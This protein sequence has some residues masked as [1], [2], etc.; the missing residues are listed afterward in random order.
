MR[1][2]LLSIIPIL[3][4]LT[5]CA[6][7]PAPEF[8]G[9]WKPV[10]RFAAAPQA[11]ALQPAYEYY[12]TP[13]DGS[14]RAM[15]VRWASDA[16]MKLSYQAPMD[17]TLYGPVAQLRADDVPDAIAQLSAI[18]AAQ[19]LAITTEGNQIVVRPAETAAAPSSAP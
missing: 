10:N 4:V 1:S 5:S 2:G 11:I 12:A 19:G 6:T 16:N 18:Y 3:V 15:L 9:R 8:S 13:L 14:L 17:Y 7:A